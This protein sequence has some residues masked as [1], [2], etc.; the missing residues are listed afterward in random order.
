M[1]LSSIL[2][3]NIENTENDPSRQLKDNIDIKKECN[4]ICIKELY[5]EIPYILIDIN[6]KIIIS[7][8]SSDHHFCDSLLSIDNNI[9]TILKSNKN[10]ESFQ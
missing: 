1:S 3:I 4:N 2:C 9:I 6:R 10:F 7:S 5:T 8:G